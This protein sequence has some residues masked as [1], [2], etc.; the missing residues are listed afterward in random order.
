MGLEEQIAAWDA[1]DKAQL[2]ISR[3]QADYYALIAELEALEKEIAP[4]W[5]PIFLAD[6]GADVENSEH[7][8]AGSLAFWQAMYR[9]AAMAA[10]GRGEER[11]LDINNLLGRAIY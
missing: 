2:A 7:E 5:N 1:E 9:S 6:E 11:G 4:V 10:G 8:P 3:A